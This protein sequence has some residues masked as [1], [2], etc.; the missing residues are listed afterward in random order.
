MKAE[1]D[2][3][4]RL[5]TTYNHTATH[6][7][8]A[9]LRRVLGS[10]VNQAGSVVHPDYLRFDFTHFEKLSELQALEIEGLVNQKIRENIP[11]IFMKP[12]TIKPLPVELLPFLEKN[13]TTG[14]GSCRRLTIH[15][16]CAADA[17]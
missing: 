14:C 13:M 11:S 5:T 17:T 2:R 1:V 7:L 16:N 9:A 8:H 6:L 15:R 10:H 4:L 12:D 3:E